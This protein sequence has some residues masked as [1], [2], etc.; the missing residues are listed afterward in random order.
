M[1]IEWMI[2][3]WLLALEVSPPVM[4][5][6]FC[7]AFVGRPQPLGNTMGGIEWR[8]W[9]QLH[10][11]DG[12]AVQV[13]ERQPDCVSYHQNNVLH[14]IG[15]PADVSRRGVKAWYERGNPTKHEI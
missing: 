15:G 11:L 12:P 2:A 9:D 8:R 3:Y 5:A 4:D 13:Y 14:R 6:L 1:N 7:R 10:R